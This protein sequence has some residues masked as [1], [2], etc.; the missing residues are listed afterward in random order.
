MSR[1]RK[2]YGNWNDLINDVPVTLEVTGSPCF[3]VEFVGLPSRNKVYKNYHHRGSVTS[4]W[5]TEGREKAADFLEGVYDGMGLTFMERLE[6]WVSRALVIVNVHLGNE[7]I[8][9][10][11]NSDIKAV[12]DGFSDAMVWADDEWAFVPLVLYA[13]AGIDVGQKRRV[14]RVVIE[15]FELGSFIV[16]NEARRLPKGRTR[17]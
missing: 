14:P 1:H 9:D 6:P 2:L 3:A 11:H 7:G 5:R 12:L 15:V 13:W 4:K 17:L 16:N 8:A 10:C